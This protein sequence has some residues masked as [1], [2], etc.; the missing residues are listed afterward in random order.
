MNRGFSLLELVI[1]IAVLGIIVTIALPRIGN[2]DKLLLTYAAQQL[3]A[4]LRLLQEEN[5]NMAFGSNDFTELKS[6]LR[7]Q[8]VFFNNKNCGYYIVRG[9][10]VIRSFSFPSGVQLQGFYSSIVF[11]KNSYTKPQHINLVNKNQEISVIID[12]AGRVRIQ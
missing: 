7:P 6:P 5:Y 11:D 12:S 8:M 1:A 2:N 9:T 10:K 4:D 3:T